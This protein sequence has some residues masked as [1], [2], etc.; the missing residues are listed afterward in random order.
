M[1]IEF[2]RGGGLLGRRA[3]ARLDLG[4]LPAP[5]RETIEKLVEA[6]SFFSLP[7]EDVSRAPDAFDYV[8]DVDDGTRR[9]RVHTDD[10]RAPAPLRPLLEK[11]RGYLK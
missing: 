4:A 2:S 7:A 10:A 9:H 5:E 11:L 1:K 8:V 6:A 3:T